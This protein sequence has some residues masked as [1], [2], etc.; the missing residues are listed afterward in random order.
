MSRVCQAVLISAMTAFGAGGGLGQ[1]GDQR[2]REA[3]VRQ[4]WADRHT[5]LLGAPSLD[6]RYLSFVDWETGD[7]AVRDLATGQNYRLTNKGSW[8]DSAECAYFSVFS[9]DSRQVA[10]AWFNEKKFYELRVVSI[11]DTRPPLLYPSSEWGAGRPPGPLWSRLELGP[12]LNPGVHGSTPRVLYRSD[13]VQFIKPTF[14]SM[15][16]KYIL[17]LV[18]GRKILNQIVLFSAADGS[19]KILKTPFWIYPKMMGMSPDGRWIV[20]S[21]N[22]EPPYIQHDIYLLST[23][24]TQDIPLVEHPAND[25]FPI[26]APDG[27]SI[28]F[29]SDRSGTMGVWVIPMADAK[30]QGPPVM[31]KKDIGRFLPLGFSRKGSFYY[32]L[33]TGTEDAYVASLD[34]ATGKVLESPRP[35]SKLLAGINRSPDWSLDG[36]Q[37]AFL[38]HVDTENHGVEMR[39][40]TVQSA[41]TGE[42]RQ[43]GVPKLGYLD[44]L[45]WSPDGRSFLVGGADTVNNFGGLYRVDAETGQETPLVQGEFAPPRGFQGVW[46]RDGNALFYVHEDMRETSTSIRFRDLET[47]Q[48]RTLHQTAA[49]WR[50]N[51]LALSP[52]GRLLAFGLSDGNRT[53]ATVLLVLPAAGGEPREILKL[54][55]ESL[56]GVTWTRDGSYLLFSRA[57]KGKPELWRIPAQGGEAKSLGLASD[58]NARISFHPD[59]RRIAFTAGETNAEVWV[60]ENFLPPPEAAR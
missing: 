19:V 25:Q 50:H 39:V 22:Q 43:F 28:L 13:E 38:S 21:L 54:K 11:E 12:L 29:T 35:V 6:G 10:Y 4:V 52:D 55:K 44:W 57:G 30:A 9:P 3:E 60:M 58:E 16:G 37:L 36:K 18:F 27:K 46:S 47:G 1:S 17:A 5:D 42:E 7:L 26:W 41:E 24:G 15:D 45:R 32:G 40:V 49:H 53:Q 20:Y 14:W 23:D 59:G 31:V 56:S 2:F 8:R 34:P 33:R 48:E 51:N